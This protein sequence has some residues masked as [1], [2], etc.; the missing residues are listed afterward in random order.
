[1][2]MMGVAGSGKSSVGA[3]VS[4]L[5][6]VAYVDGDDLHPKANIDKMANGIPLTDEDRAPWLDEV[7]HT[8]ARAQ[9]PTIIGCS[10]LKRIYRDR[11]RAQAGRDTVFIHL[12][13]ERSVIEQRM[14]DR[15]GHFMPVALL[16]S[17]FEALE[18]PG[19]D[20]RAV[21]VDIDQPLDAIA[22]EIVHKLGL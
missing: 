7:G 9:A 16:D 3:A 1:M 19:E 14:G 8:L 6:G 15:T 12:T 17:Q 11:I 13:G 22:G 2:V 18:P 21:A 20:E 4:A 5:T 10:A